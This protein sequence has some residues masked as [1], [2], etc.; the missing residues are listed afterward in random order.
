MEK[1]K[2]TVEEALL[3][4]RNLEEA[5][6]ENVKGVL[7]S[8]M[9]EE[10]KELVK[11]S[12]NEQAEVED[13]EEDVD[14]EDMGGEED[15]EMDME[16][17]GDEM[18]SDEEEMD[19]NMD[20]EEMDMDDEEEFDA[21]DETVDLTGASDD[22]VLKVFKAMGDEDGI[23]VK[24]EDDMIH[25]EDGEDEYLVQLGESYMEEDEDLTMDDFELG[26]GETDT[27]YEIEFNDEDEDYEFNDEDEDY[28]FN[29]LEEEF[30][31]DFSEEDYSEQFEEEEMVSLE[32]Q[33]MEAL[34]SKMR[35]KGEGIGHGPKF[36]Y[37]KKPN[38]G[39][40]FNEKKKEGP[41]SVGTGKAKFEYK[42][43]K[44]FGSKKHEYKRKKVDGVEKKSGEDKDGHY[45]DYEKSETKEAVRTNSY[46][47]ANKVGNRKGSNQNVNREEIR[48]R[49]NTRSVNEEVEMLRERNEEYKKALDVF[50]TKLNEVAIFNSN[51]AYA[52]RLFTEHSTTKQEKINILR[53]FDEVESLKESKNLYRTMKGELTNT[54]SNEK[55]ITESIEKTVKTPA[56]GSAANLIESK[57]YE[58]PQFLRMKDLM[59]KIN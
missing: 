20:D 28:E 31:D 54:T 16:D 45:K 13:E 36:S 22:E 1:N 53:R 4:I 55:T 5:L 43:E 42:E 46:P 44:E 47:R 30:E 19:F 9:K 35:P 50:R 49:P 15:V 48:V 3:Q 41:K 39:G 24:R 32:D 33:I 58:N 56:S 7:R 52:T 21:D 59:S 25:L 10:I 17:M 18:D 38:M 14:I 34:K 8:T 51:L 11:E 57:T 23:I 27:L 26:E 29:D 6:Q 37:D 2:N 12:L 40:G